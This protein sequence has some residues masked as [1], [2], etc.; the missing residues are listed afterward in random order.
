MFRQALGTTEPPIQWIEA[1]LSSGTKRPV[2][3]TDYS[4]PSSGEVHVF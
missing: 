1:A 2:R 4:S 3:E